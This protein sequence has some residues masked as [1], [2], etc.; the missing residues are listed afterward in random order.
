MFRAGGLALP[1]R[2][3]GR[4]LPAGKISYGPEAELARA[5]ART[6]RLSIESW[7]A[8]SSRGG[9]GNVTAGMIVRASSLSWSPT[10]MR[11]VAGCRAA[12]A[13]LVAAPGADRPKPG[14]TDCPPGSCPSGPEQARPAARAWLDGEHPAKSLV[15]SESRRSSGGDRRGVLRGGPG[16][17]RSARARRARRGPARLSPGLRRLDQAALTRGNFGLPAGKPTRHPCAWRRSHEG[18]RPR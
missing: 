13:G 5:A 7:R 17:R 18:R 10:G 1:F 12:R 4:A 15:A 6:P 16:R 9:R 14:E 8:R 2:E 11:P 3:A